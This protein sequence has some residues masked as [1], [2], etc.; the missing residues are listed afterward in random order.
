MDRP[1]PAPQ[2][3]AVAGQH[4][5]A[6]ELVDDQHGARCES[7]GA[8]ALA[9]EGGGST[10]GIRTCGPVRACGRAVRRA[11][12]PRRAGSGR[13]RGEHDEPGHHW[14]RKRQELS[15]L[16]AIRIAV[17]GVL[18]AWPLAF[19][20]S[21]PGHT[22][23]TL[24]RWRVGACTG[25]A[26]GCPMVIGKDTGSGALRC[27]RAAWSPSRTWLPGSITRAVRCRA[28]RGVIAITVAGSLGLLA[29]LGAAPASGSV[30]G[31]GIAQP[32]PGTQLLVSR[33]TGSGSSTDVAFAVAASPDGKTVFVTG[34]P[35]YTTIAY[36]AATGA[37]LWVKHYVAGTSP[38]A[39]VASPD[40]STV[41]VTGTS[42]G[43]GTL[44]HPD[45]VTIAYNAATGAQLWARRYN[46]RANNYDAANSV[47][48]APGGRTVYI[49]GG[50]NGRTS[51]RDM[52]TVAYRAGTGA[53]LWARRYNGPGNR[54]DSGRSVA[55]IPGGRTVVVTGPSASAGIPFRNY[56]TIA[57]NAR[58][59]ARRWVSRYGGT[60]GSAKPAG[61]VISPDGSTVFVTG[62]A[63]PGYGTVAYAGATGAQLW[64][65]TYVGPGSIDEATGLAVSPD[66]SRLYVTGGSYDRSLARAWCPGSLIRCKSR[67]SGS[68]I[69]SADFVQ[70]KGLGFSFHVSTQARMSFS[71]CLTDLWAPR[72]SSF[73]V[74]SPNQRS[75]WFS[76]DE[77]VGVK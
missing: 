17:L 46:G 48:V 8:V 35:G 14:W 43:T 54:Y 18:R 10:R 6:A 26:G 2:N 67:P 32:A 23:T 25:R 30:S 75:T 47:A 1:E 77:L 68:R 61:M 7:A 33:Y 41:Y 76:Q 65:S 11:G 31:G 44:G 24:A 56:A 13:S 5:V 19:P 42:P 59:G 27:L 73:P 29:G 37:Q 34:Q 70:M 52:F 4:A 39:V 53:Q 71:S 20:L 74:K 57:Y 36:D 28:G 62:T 64:A 72:R 38:K 12:R 51:N 60:G 49:T 9:A 21:A 63:S 22:R 16:A 55:V 50:S 3:A 69:S 45:Y 66:G 40:G 15:R 58:T